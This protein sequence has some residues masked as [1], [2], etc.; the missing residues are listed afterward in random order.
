MA[1]DDQIK[2]RLLEVFDAVMQTGRVTSAA[3]YLGISQPAVSASIQRLEAQLGFVLF[4]REGRV[5]APTPAA[6]HLAEAVR[7]VFSAM[8][9]LTEEVRRF[10]R[11]GMAHLRIATTPSLGHG[12]ALDAL[13][14]L[15]RGDPEMRADVT[16]CNDDQ[17]LQAVELGQADIGIVLGA[18]EETDLHR[19]LLPPTHLVAVIPRDHALTKH[20][21]LGPAE[22]AKE[23]LIDAGRVIS[24]LVAGS[25]ARQ[26][27]VYSPRFEAHQSQTACAMV[28]AG[29]GVTVVDVFAAELYASKESLIRRFYPPTKL[30]NTVLRPAAI[31]ESKA[32]VLADYTRL[33]HAATDHV[34]FLAHQHRSP[35]YN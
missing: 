28:R 7:P 13:R 12:V 21:T 17:V 34:P 2:I 24:P 30:T 27:V 5:L 4:E 3:S 22:L 14:D 8:A 15:R 35:I 25:F 16:V 18:I 31:P 23:D 1:Q 29:L 10:A 19:T 32:R 11:T 6:R 26:G 20:A 33:L 9:D